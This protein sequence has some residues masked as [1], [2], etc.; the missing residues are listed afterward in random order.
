MS[1]TKMARKIQSFSGKNVRDP[2]AGSDRCFAQVIADA[3]HRDFGE[4][5]AAVKIVAARTKANE[6][7]VKNWFMAKNGPTGQYLVELIRISDEVLEAVLLMC[8]R[9]ELVINNKLLCSRSVLIRMLNLIGDL[10]Q[11]SAQPKP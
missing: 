10:Q 2:A 1:S 8:G 9:D 3:L 11:I 7:A 6:R 5:H 4:T